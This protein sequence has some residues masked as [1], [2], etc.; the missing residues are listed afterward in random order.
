M[1]P[2]PWALAGHMDEHCAV[3]GCRALAAAMCSHVEPS[4]SDGLFAA[5]ALRIGGHTFPSLPRPVIVSVVILRWGAPH[6]IPGGSAGAFVSFAHLRDP[7]GDARTSRPSRM[8]GQR[9]PRTHALMV[10][11]PTPRRSAVCAKGQQ[12]ASHHR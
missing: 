2:Q 6:S 4:W 1:F 11:T 12:L 5:G 8:M 7:C 9:S 3:F 10:S